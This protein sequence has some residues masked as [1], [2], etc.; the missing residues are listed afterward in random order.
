MVCFEKY[1]WHRDK[2]KW[3]RKKEGINWEIKVNRCVD[4]EG[5]NGEEVIFLISYISYKKLYFLH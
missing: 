3:G 5:D 4:K 1:W 2:S